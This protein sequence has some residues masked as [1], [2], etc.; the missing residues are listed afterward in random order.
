MKTLTQSMS[1]V[2]LGLSL[3]PLAACDSGAE[4]A[5]A[6]PAPVQVASR[7]APEKCYECGTITSFE[8]MKAKGKGTGMGIAIGAV[9]GA[10]AGH[11]VG[12][13]RGKDAA[14]VGGAVVGGFAGNEVEKRAR[15]T[16]YFHV[17]I[18]MEHGGMRT[19]DVD[20]M[21]GLS[22]GSH[23]KIVGGNLQVVA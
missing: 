11:Q 13:G 4:P 15:G 6:A 20:A 18:A 17:T 21:N 7:P 19:V 14:T 22:A 9:L 10:V 23:V 1:V 8:E 3:A 5:A 2:L 12:D 16:T